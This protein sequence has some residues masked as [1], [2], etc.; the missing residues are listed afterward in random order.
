M[1]N[2]FFLVL[3]AAVGLIR[4]LLQAAETK[5]N[6]DAARRATIPPPNAPVARSANESEEERVRKFFE[7]LGLPASAAPSP[8]TPSP[9]AKRSFLPV[10]P[11]PVPRTGAGLP[12][13]IARPPSPALPRTAVPFEIGPPTST[14]LPLS[15]KS[16]AVTRAQSTPA[17]FE[18]HKIDL[19]SSIGAASSLASSEEVWTA[20]REIAARLATPEG[21]REV[22]ILREIFGPPRS[23]QPFAH[24]FL[25]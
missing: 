16:Q 20:P 4:L 10:D 9:R 1:E 22:I 12:P 23:M 14:P 5:K 8:R 17:L 2:I 15:S 7:A 3:V 25:S 11:F 18:V 24:D 21:L 13:V 19:A 6:K